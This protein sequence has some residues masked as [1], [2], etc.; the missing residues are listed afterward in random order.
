MDNRLQII[1]SVATGAVVIAVIVLAAGWLKN[2]HSATVTCTFYHEGAEDAAASWCIFNLEFPKGDVID[3]ELGWVNT[4]EFVEWTLTHEWSGDACSKIEVWVEV[5]ASGHS[6]MEWEYHL[7][8]VTGLAMISGG[9]YT[10]DC[11]IYTYE[12]EDQTGEWDAYCVHPDMLNP[13][14]PVQIGTVEL[15]LHN[16]GEDYQT[17]WITAGQSTE[18]FGILGAQSSRNLSIPV[19]AVFDYGSYDCPVVVYSEWDMPDYEGILQIE[20]G[21]HVTLSVTI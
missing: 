11:H 3:T 18:V 10:M 14:D 7:M 19:S 17:Y 2:S 6:F 15:N 4:G 5:T 9:A 21:D 8:D 16:D 1:A 12:S 13:F 20:K